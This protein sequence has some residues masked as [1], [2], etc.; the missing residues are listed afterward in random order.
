MLQSQHCL[1]WLSQLD[2]NS[3]ILKS[4][5][6]LQSQSV[7]NLCTIIT[8]F[9]A[10]NRTHLNYHKQFLTQICFQD[11]PYTAS[12]TFLFS[13]GYI[14]LN[15]E[16]TTRNNKIITLF[17]KFAFIYID[18]KQVA[19]PREREVLWQINYIAA[20]KVIETIGYM[21]IKLI[22]YWWWNQWG[23]YT[24]Y[25]RSRK[26]EP[27]WKTWKTRPPYQTLRSNA[28]PLGP[29]AYIYR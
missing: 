4:S 9:F 27:W 19:T 6:T 13:S 28:A 23:D 14:I 16:K 12:P 17:K 20:T 24:W 21:M 1:T 11:T 25:C 8:E 29:R 22:T 5:E 15:I 10:L 26:Q 3:L 7:S 2:V 18:H